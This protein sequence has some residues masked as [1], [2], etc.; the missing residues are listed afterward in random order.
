VHYAFSIAR[1]RVL[2]CADCKF[3][4][5][6]EAT[7]SRVTDGHAAASALAARAGDLGT[8]LRSLAPEVAT[9]HGSRIVAWQAD[10]AVGLEPG[11]GVAVSV[12]QLEA[13]ADPMPSLEALR[14]LVTPGEPVVFVFSDVRC[15]GVEA[16][17]PAWDRLIA[18]RHAFLDT[19]AALTVL[20]RAGFRCRGV[21][22]LRR[23]ATIAEVL[24]DDDGVFACR[25]WQRRLF[26]LVPGALRRRIHLDARLADVGILATPRPT[27]EPLVSVVVPVFNEAATVARVLD[28]VL[29]VRFEGAGLEVVIVE[30]NSTDGSR[31][32]VQR[33]AGRAGVICL[34]ED[35]PRGK[36]HATRLGLAH[37]R[38]DVLLI[39]DADL[40]YDVEDFHA[41]V[42]PILR[43]HEAFVLG[44]RHGGRSHWKL[45]QFGKPLLSKFYNVAHVLVTAYI[46]I[47]FGLSLRDPQTMY[48]V[49]RRDCYEGLEFRGNYFDFDYEFLLKIV[50]RGYT[51]VEVPVNYRSRS[52]AEGKKL[53]MRRDAPLGLLMI[54]RLRLLRLKSFLR[55]GEPIE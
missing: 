22:R 52:H 12:G 51:P 54:T 25:P 31:E 46:N 17:T 43:G 48:K 5:R 6:T 37:A 36:G 38:G 13:H 15:S 2:Q 55:V 20:Y 50:R 35:R 29:G 41:L 47:L 39:Q 42:E 3:T 21:Q 27:A 26:R 1:A 30:S 45:R 8:A 40:E 7:R 16:G 19:H 49:C 32:I 53:T 10:G 28:A 14:R 44:S 24:D 11:P 4:A 9:A 34:F 18:E 23:R 33:Y